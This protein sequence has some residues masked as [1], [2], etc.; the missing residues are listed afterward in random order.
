MPSLAVLSM[1]TSPLAQP[2]TGDGGGMNVYVRELC[3]ALAR[4]GVR[5]EVFTRAD[6]TGGTATVNVEPSFRVHHVPAGPLGPV[7]KERLPDLVP[8]WTAGGRAAAWPTLAGGRR[9]GRRHP[10]Q[11]LAVGPGRAHP[12]ARA[13][14]AAARHLPHPGPGQGRRQPGGALGAPSRPGG[15]RPRPRSSAAPTPSWPRARWRRTSW[16]SCTA[17]TRT[18]SPSWRRASTT[19]SSAPATRRRPAARWGC[20]RASR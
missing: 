5:C 10:R 7:A 20:E 12:Q 13:G 17:P 18:G 9:A 8:A 3:A 6:G 1:H 2:G 15:P 4:S 19:P 11:L 16:S 14:R